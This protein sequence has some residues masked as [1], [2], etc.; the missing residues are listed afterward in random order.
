MRKWLIIL[1]L[2]ALSFAQK[3][4]VK[5]WIRINQLGYTPNGTKV[6]V[7]C[8]NDQLT[9]SN[10]QLAEVKTN[11]IVFSGKAGKAFGSYGPFKQTYRL[12]FSSF[13]KPGKYYL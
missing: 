2:P 4:E 7:W 10:W 11:K 13:K 5:S 1:L 3:N 6:A 12:D 8:S 9:I